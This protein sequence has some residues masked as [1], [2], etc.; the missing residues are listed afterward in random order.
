MIKEK[1]QTDIKRAM[2][3][4]KDKELSVLRLLSAAV[5]NKE[6]EKQYKQSKDTG[7]SK[8]AEL[9]DEEAIEVVSSE[10]KKL[11]DALAL[12]EK[13][14][15]ADLV[16][17]TKGEIAVLQNY[18]PAQLTEEELRGLVLEAVE[19]TQASSIKDMGKVMADLMP[20]VK[21]K[22]DASLVSRMVQECFKKG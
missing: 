5:L 17:K 11:R 15:R 8:K 4:K 9:D 22:A 6:K 10:V 14:Q 13:G 21:G 18:L 12:F 19:K 20:K 16:E 2:I 7:E 1:I 3:A